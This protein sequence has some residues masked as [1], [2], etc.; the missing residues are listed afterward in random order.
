MLLMRS[1]GISWDLLGKGKVRLGI[2]Q[3]PMACDDPLHP[4]GKSQEAQLWMDFRSLV[5]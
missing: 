1:H 5:C 3:H 2:L 4:P